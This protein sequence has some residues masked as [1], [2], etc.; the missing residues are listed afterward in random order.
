MS[1][2]IKLLIEVDEEN[3][4]LIKEMADVAGMSFCEILRNGTPYNPTDDLISRS[5]LKSH[6]FLSPQVKVVGS[7]HNGKTKEQIVEAYQKGWNDCI[8]AITDNAPTVEPR[9]EY[10]TDGHPYKLSITNGKEYDRPSGIE[11]DVVGYEGLY[12]VDIF[13]TVR[14][15][16]SG[17]VVEHYVNEFGYHNVYLYKNK[18]KKGKRVNRLVAMAFIPNPLNKPQVNHI[19]GNKDNNN[20][21]NLEWATNKENS[22]H[23]GKT[24]LYGKGAVKI[25]ETG[26]VFP[27]VS[28][29]A[30]HLSVEPSNI[31]KCLKG[32]RNKVRGYHCE[33]VGADMRGDE[34][35]KS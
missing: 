24:G 6:K 16:L 4:Q 1:K 26:E 14:N 17:K 15:L 5:E 7:R 33:K 12:S 13:G 35:G 8:D 20:V 31:Y 21:W 11:R 29:L 18:E 32:E 10:G 25:V 9:I 22:I 34:N 30:R 2:K 19:D 23:A 27:N 28:S 3:Y